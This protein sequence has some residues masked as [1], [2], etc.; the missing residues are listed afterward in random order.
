MY[1]PIGIEMYS[2]AVMMRI[3]VSQATENEFSFLSPLIR[4]KAESNFT[5]EIH[6]IYT[7]RSRLLSLFEGIPDAFFRRGLA[8]TITETHLRTVNVPFGVTKSPQM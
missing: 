3:F 1:L 6:L 7:R 8:D 2:V 5:Q 4:V